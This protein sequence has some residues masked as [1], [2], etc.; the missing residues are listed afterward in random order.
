MGLSFGKRIRFIKIWKPAMIASSIIVAITCT[1]SVFLTHYGIIGVNQDFTLGLF[2]FS[3]PIE[4]ILFYFSFSF[5]VI[6]I[7]ELSKLWYKQ[8]GFKILNHSI[9]IIIALFM[10]YIVCTDTSGYYTITVL[11]LTTASI[12][13]WGIFGNLNKIGITIILCILPYIITR[14]ILIGELGSSFPI[15]HDE[16]QQHSIQIG[17]LP[18]EEILDGFSLIVASIVTFEIIQ[19]MRL[20]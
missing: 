18:L 7:Y 3:I 10:L 11:C 16:S 9:R 14:L 19:K 13:A 12:I 2:I 17:T 1:M 20:K 8:R 15:W 4:E 6:F 5:F